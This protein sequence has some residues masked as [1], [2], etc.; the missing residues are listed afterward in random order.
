MNQ[1]G[2]SLQRLLRYADDEDMLN[3]IVTGDESWVHHYQPESKCA[4]MQWKRS[5]SPSTK[6]FKVT[7]IPSIGRV[8]LTVFWDSPGV[9]LAHF[10]KRDE[11]MNSASYCE[12]L[13]KLRDTVR[14]KGSRPTVKGYCF[15]MTMPDPIQPKQPR[16]E[17]KKY[18][19]NFLNFH[20]TV[21]TWPLVTSMCLVCKETTLVAKVLL[22][23]KRVKQRC[24][25][26]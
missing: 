17:F 16:R 8:M 25:N 2:L 22:M 19:G 9:L 15:I 1:M 10:Q 13:L 14:K 21:Q 4:S 3:R 18:S 5:S 7:C 23:M 11:N 26:G 20:L 24:G 12:V 6:K